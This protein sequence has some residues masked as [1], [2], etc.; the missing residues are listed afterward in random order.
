MQNKYQFEDNQQ[1]QRD[2]FADTLGLK[3]NFRSVHRN[4]GN[5][6]ET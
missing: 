3:S 1:F 6:A 2:K 4:G 5:N